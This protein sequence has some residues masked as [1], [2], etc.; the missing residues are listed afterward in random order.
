MPELPEVETSRRGIE[1]WIVDTTIEKVIVRDRRL[2]WPV[3]RGVERKLEGR[4]IDSVERRA[5]YLLMY[6]DQGNMIWHLGMSGSLRILPGHSPTLGHEHIRVELDNG[7]TLRF[8]DPRRFGALLYSEE[9][10]YQEKFRPY[11]FP[12][13]DWLADLADRL[14][15]KRPR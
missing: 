2:R 4:S 1:P 14:R 3:A 8:R 15:R 10:G 5:K 11:A 13:P 7:Q 6:T 9:H 12:E